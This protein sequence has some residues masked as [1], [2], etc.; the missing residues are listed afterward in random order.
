M[1]SGDQ[2]NSEGD[3]HLTEGV[4]PLLFVEK[5]EARK[6]LDL[7]LELGGALAAIGEEQDESRH[8]VRLKGAWWGELEIQ[9]VSIEQDPGREGFL[10]LFESL[11]SN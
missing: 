7:D 10:T 5:E 1:I 11:Q 8:A 2:L 4:P 6:K 9:R 3:S